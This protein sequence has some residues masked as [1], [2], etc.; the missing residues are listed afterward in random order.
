MIDKVIGDGMRIG[1][2]EATDA[3]RAPGVLFTFTVPIQNALLRNLH[4][5]YR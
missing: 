3:N 4:T 2:C 1:G 5:S